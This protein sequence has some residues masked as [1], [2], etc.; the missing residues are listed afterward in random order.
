MDQ[1]DEFGTDRISDHDGPHRMSRR[2]RGVALLA[3]GLVAG[4]ALAGATGAFAAGSSSPSSSATSSSGTS[5]ATPSGQPAKG[6]HQGG[7]MG[8]STSVRSDEKELTGTAAAKVK[9]AALKAVPGATVYRVE[10]DA[11]DGVYEA[12]LTKANGTPATVKL[13]K[14]FVVTKIES[15][16]GLGDPKPAGGP[17]GHGRSAA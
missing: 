16:T 8:G 2:G 10:T 3:A 12:H 6:D 11:G 17:D 7:Q 1:D 14:D 9:A 13:S 5:T 15:G 4:G